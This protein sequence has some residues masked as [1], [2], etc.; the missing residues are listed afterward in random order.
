MVPIVL[1]AMVFGPLVKSLS[2][3][4]E[5][6]RQQRSLLARETALL[7]SAPQLPARLASA[8]RE[9]SRA[10]SRLFGGADPLMAAADFSRHVRQ[11]AGSAQLEV[12]QVDARAADST[13]EGSLTLEVSLQALGDL[14][15]AL[16]FLRAVER[17]SM[18]M[19]ATSVR[20]E[21]AE[22]ASLVEESDIEAM[23]DLLSLHV[24]LQGLARSRQADSVEERVQ[25]L[26][27]QVRAL[28]SA[29]R[30]T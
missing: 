29:E 6:L 7:R 8:R 21:R 20:I 22:G 2:T 30:P 14:R 25:A 26:P 16:A 23:E 24:I 27:Q 18:L 28:R 1:Y 11:L 3:A 19:H 10:E 15:N 5:S 9:L 12:L 13:A 17:D 4:R